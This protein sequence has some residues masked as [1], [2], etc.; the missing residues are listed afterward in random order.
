MALPSPYS[1]KKNYFFFFSFSFFSQTI[2]DGKVQ[3]PTL[4]LKQ[5]A[6]S[7]TGLHLITEK[8]KNA[9]PPAFHHHLHLVAFFEEE[10][11][12]LSSVLCGQFESVLEP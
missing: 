8:V 5:D 10:N 7:S 12:G 9:I 6:R 4:I 11:K 2:S 3:I 1:Q